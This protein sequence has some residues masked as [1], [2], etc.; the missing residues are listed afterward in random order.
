VVARKDT[1]TAPAIF[2]SFDGLASLL[3]V[4]VFLLF[5]HPAL[6]LPATLSGALSSAVSMGGGEWLSDSDSGFRASAVMAGA[7][8]LGALLPATPFGFGHGAGEIGEAAII[9]V[10]IAVVVAL[11]RRDRSLPLAL[12]ETFGILAA[13]LAVTVLCGIFLPSGAG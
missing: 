3:G 11:M 2:G 6:I 5:S 12:A 13:V 7:T 10:L 9:C 8:F 4:V 1:L